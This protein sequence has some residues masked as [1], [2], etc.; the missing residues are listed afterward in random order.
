M[1]IPSFEDIDLEQ[2]EVSYDS[3][4]ARVKLLEELLREEKARSDAFEFR[5]ECDCGSCRCGIYPPPPSRDSNPVGES[6][7]PMCLDGE[8]PEK[9][10]VVQGDWYTGTDGNKWV[11]DGCWKRA[12]G[13][14]TNLTAPPASLVNKYYG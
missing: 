13:V 10:G 12:D 6:R 4:V 14:K 2:L 9:G 5:I 1:G 7:E 8:W 3:L 11:M